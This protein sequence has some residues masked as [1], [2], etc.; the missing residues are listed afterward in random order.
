[1][2]GLAFVD[3]EML[4]SCVV[5]FECAYVPF[6]EGECPAFFSFFFFFRQFLKEDCE[7]RLRTKSVDFPVGRVVKN[8]PA[9]SGYTG[10]ISRLGS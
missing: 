2:R 8:L 7:A 5:C 1:M 9:N 6:C 3:L 4:K 10:L